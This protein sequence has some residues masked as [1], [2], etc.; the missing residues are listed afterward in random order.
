VNGLV[1]YE[2][3]INSKKLDEFFQYEYEEED[4]SCERVWKTEQKV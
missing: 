4:D 1:S 2:S 3:K